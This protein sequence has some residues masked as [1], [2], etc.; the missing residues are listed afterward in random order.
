M[1]FA[2]GYVGIRFSSFV[3]SKEVMEGSRISF[4]TQNN[5]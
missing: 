2:L 1:I 3:D 5:S 4:V